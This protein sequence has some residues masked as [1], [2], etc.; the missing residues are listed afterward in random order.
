MEHQLIEMMPKRILSELPF[1]G[2][3]YL[4]MTYTFFADYMNKLGY[5]RSSE[6]EQQVVTDQEFIHAFI[7]L[8][9]SSSGYFQY[10]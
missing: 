1:V 5:F 2:S 6:C 8:N 4:S 3:W 9:I 10:F 7:E